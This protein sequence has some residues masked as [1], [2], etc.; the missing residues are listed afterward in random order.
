[1]IRFNA[2]R[3]KSEASVSSLTTLVCKRAAHDHATCNG[4]AYFSSSSKMTHSAKGQILSLLTK[5]Q[6]SSTCFSVL[7]LSGNE[8]LYGPRTK[9]MKSLMSL[10][11]L[12]GCSGFEA[13]KGTIA[14]WSNTKLLL[15]ICDCGG[16]RTINLTGGILVEGGVQ[17][18]SE[19]GTL[20]GTV[21]LKGL[22]HRSRGKLP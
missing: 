17:R 8:S 19:P 1:M 2:G 6:K 15:S 9:A 3:C 16:L 12:A 22:V 7:E 5:S 4:W 20:L 10:K 13:S 21:L 11:T 18:S 14:P